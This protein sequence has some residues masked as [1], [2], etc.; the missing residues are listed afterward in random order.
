MQELAN[1]FNFGQPFD[2]NLFSNNLQTLINM[3]FSREQ[4]M[5]ALCITE[6]KGVEGALE[7]CSLNAFSHQHSG[8]CMLQ[9]LVEGDKVKR[10]RRRDEVAS[11]LGRRVA[12]AGNS[13]GAGSAGGADLAELKRQVRSNNC[14]SAWLLDA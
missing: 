5:E 8:S 3:G 4:C 9:L 10:Q 2:M 14:L 12:G 7:V 6:N 1:D 11:R 13:G